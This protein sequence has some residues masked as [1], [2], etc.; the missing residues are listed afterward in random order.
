[1]ES[2]TLNEVLDYLGNE[3]GGD[4]LLAGGSLVRLK[5]DATRG[6]EDM[7]PSG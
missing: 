7:D 5:F 2:K 1:M 6:T 3:L 4:W